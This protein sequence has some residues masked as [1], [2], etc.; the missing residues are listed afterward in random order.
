MKMSATKEQIDAIAVR[1]Q[2]VADFEAS[3]PERNVWEKS[4]Y[5]S[6]MRDWGEDRAIQVADRILKEWRA[7]FRA[8]AAE[9]ILG[10]P[11]GKCEKCGGSLFG[12]ASHYCPTP[13]RL[14]LECLNPISAHSPQCSRAAE[15]SQ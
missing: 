12:S 2:A 10:T 3:A 13:A 1:R 7:R 8:A 11:T 9:M 4:I 5:A 14:C 15:V 6:L